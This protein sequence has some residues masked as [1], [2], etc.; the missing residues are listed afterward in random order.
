MSHRKEKIKRFR[1][2][3]KER[4]QSI[5]QQRQR[6]FYALIADIP[7]DQVAYVPLDIGKNVNWFKIETGAGR[8]VH[9]PQDVPT[10]HTG[11]LV[12]KSALADSL[13]NFQLVFTCHEPTGVYHETWCRNLLT[14]FEAGLQEAAQPRL[15]YRFMNPYQVKLERQKLVQ[16]FRKTDPIDLWAM[17]SLLRQGQG[18]PATMPDPNT[19]LL[20]QYV[21]FVREA[22]RRLRAIR[23]DILRQ[24]DRIWPGAVVNLKRFKR[25]HPRLPVPTPIVSSKPMER[26]SL[27]IL[28]EHCPNP[29]HIR[30]LGVK[31]IIDLFHAHD[32]RCGLKTAQL[33]LDN[34]RQALLSP[35]AVVDVYAQS[36]HRLL[37]TEAHWLQQHAW[38]E[39]QIEPLV[40]ETPAR[41]LL[42]I[43]GVSPLWAAY[44]LDLVHYPPRFAW[45]DQIWAYV[46]FDTVL[47][48]SG[49]SNPDQRFVISRRGEAFY[50]HA[51]TW[52]SNLAA[53]HHPTFGQRFVAAEQRGLGM[54]GAA[55]H[56]AHYLNRV[57][58]HLI[59]NDEPLRDKVHPD[60]YA[61]WRAYWLAWRN[62]C[63]QPKSNPHPGVWKPTE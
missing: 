62:Y 45:P 7:P 44:Y 37:A 56:V 55:I 32:E 11:Y 10:D 63:A 3:Q 52:M 26:R 16:R 4:V 31:G 43:R 59:L 29:Y 57:C 53:G 35:P 50:R 19:A 38:A 21:Y 39:A 1:D 25:A 54:W 22:S 5:N 30:E 20:H 60:D 47:K 17:D 40:L 23:I 28:L 13:A 58:F 48:Q 41:H 36:L 2:Y 51:L 6:E 27:R 34:A 42:S 15:I 61:R 49:D 12:F 24:F 14:D 9:K 33:I 46:G 8:I 18:N